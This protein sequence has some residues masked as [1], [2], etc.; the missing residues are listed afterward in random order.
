MN[1]RTKAFRLILKAVLPPEH[2][3]VWC[4]ETGEFYVSRPGKRI[5]RLSKNGTFQNVKHWFDVRTEGKVFIKTLYDG[6]QADEY[7][8]LDPLI[9]DKL[10]ER[11]KEIK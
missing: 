9:L 3:F 10:R 8:L 4:E 2:H 1:E 5:S 6:H 11:L 7:D